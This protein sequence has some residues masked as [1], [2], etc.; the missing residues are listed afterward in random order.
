MPLTPMRV[1]QAIQQAQGSGQGPAATE[2]GKV[3]DD[4]GGGAAGSGPAAPGEGGAA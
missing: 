4:H 2:Q 3:L 1:W